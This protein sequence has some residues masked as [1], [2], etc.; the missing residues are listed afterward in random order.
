MVNFKLAK[1][2][3]EPT[4][5]SVGELAWNDPAFIQILIKKIILFLFG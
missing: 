1:S 4:D 5:Q 3:A 2:K